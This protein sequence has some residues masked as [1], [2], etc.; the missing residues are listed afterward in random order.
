MKQRI[1]MFLVVVLLTTGAVAQEKK[2]NDSSISKVTDVMEKEKY[3]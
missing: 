3:G 2:A 1:R